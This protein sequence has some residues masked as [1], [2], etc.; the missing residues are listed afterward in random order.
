[1]KT[2]MKFLDY[3]LLTILASFSATAAADTE[4]VDCSNET[5]CRV[6]DKVLFTVKPKS[7]N[8]NSPSTGNVINLTGNGMIWA[9][10]ESNFNQAELSISAP[11]SV[12]LQNGKIIKPVEFYVRSNYSAFVDNYVVSIYRGTD[13]DL[14]EPLVQLP[15]DVKA[16]SSILWDGDLPAK[17]QYRVGDS[18]IYVVRA[19]DK[20]GHFDE[21]YSQAIKLVTPEENERGN[22]AIRDSLSQNKG[23]IM[24]K[25]EAMTES[26]IDSV[27]SSNNLYRQNIPFRGSR[28]KI[29]GT[30]IPDGSNVYINGESYPID[31]NRK[32]AVD[33]LLPIGE[34]DFDITVDDKKM[35]NIERVLTVDVSGNSFFMVG[36]ADVTV[37]QNSAS[38]SNK[39]AALTD[40]EGNYNDK[41]LMSDGRIAF[42][43]KSKIDGRYTITAH[44]DTREKELQH[45]F[46]GFGRAYPEDVFRSLDPDL[47]Y[48]TYGDDSSVYRD[49]D[50]MGRF[51]LRVDWDKSQALWGNFNT[52]IAGTEYGRYSRSL[53]G[54]ALDW[55][56]IAT[57]KFGDT[58]TEL[59]G[60]ASQAQSNPGHSEFL[61][62]GGSLYYLKHTRILSGSDKVQVQISD[63]IT[64][65]VEST[66]SL[67]RGVDYEIDA[68]QGRIILAKPLTQIVRQSMPSI[69]HQDPLNGYEQRLLVDYEYIPTGF[70]PESITSGV[71]GKHWITDNIA[72]GGTYVDENQAGKDYLMKGA[73]VTLKAGNGTYIKAEYTKT[74]STGVP[75]FYSDNGG[76]SFNEVNKV[77]SNREGEA[78]AIE[79]RVN[80]KELGV[81]DNNISAGAWWHKVDK[82]Y[83]T[84]NS[85]NA[86][87]TELYGAEISADIT[88]NLLVYTRHTKVDKGNKSYIESQ[89]SSEWRITDDSTVTA[90]VKRVE[91]KIGADKA[92]GMLAAMQ[93]S[94]QYN[95][96]IELYGSG[97]ITLDNDSGEYANNDAVT[98]GFKYLYGDL[99]SIGIEGTTGARGSSGLLF[100]EH[101]L[102]TDHT[103]YANYTL[104]DSKSDYSS[105]FNSNQGGWTVGQRWR[106]TDR[107][108][109]FNETQ[110]LKGSANEK[111]T[112]NT[113]GVDYLLDEGWSTNV[114]VQD[115]KLKRSTDNAKIHRTAVS[116]S[117]SRTTDDMDWSSKVEYRHDSGAEHRRQWLTTNRVNWKFNESLRLSGKFNYSET[118]DMVT[119]VDEAKFI[120]SGIGFAWRPWDNNQWALFGRY[121]YLYDDSSNGQDSDGYDQKSHIFS[122]EGVHKLNA[123]WEF[124]AKVAYRQSE[125]RFGYLDDWFD[126]S[127]S[128]AAA[129]IRYDLI[130]KWHLMGEYRWLKV[131]DGGTK[132]GFLAG[133]DYDISDYLRFG[134]GYNFTDF[135]DDL[136]KQDYKYKGFFINVVGY[137]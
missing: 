97:Q 123:Q 63:K 67:T 110:Q 52:G 4:V 135:S 80:L 42:Y 12:P 71:R 127:A 86:E 13:T 36:M 44:A 39:E 41:D 43:M 132:Q 66:I 79:G 38:G 93:Y 119:E 11:S 88:D 25:E 45:L 133:I 90:E 116:A 16:I 7:G 31:L 1:M 73:D 64:G 91:T 75:I 60:F 72:V 95:S 24:T 33:F 65:R 83:S 109:L 74:E 125:K 76:L 56:S 115:G 9:S 10:E 107:I 134:L 32:F 21:T 34:H 111:G 112:A 113:I 50:T 124:A 40:S 81:T 108:N 121:N 84:S 101:R 18:L 85:D 47:Y 51:Y 114:T 87:D 26:L 128:F 78:K 22:T 100:A 105:A 29:Q 96:S 106:L 55:R 54:A 99:S 14:I 68:V 120:E 37:Y 28:V 49:V 82:G 94:Y 35:G 137:Y 122:L 117:I 46:S 17:Y 48:P 129:Q 30:N 2:R 61:G 19:Y 59:R 62:T 6:D 136:T 70:E 102:S 8:A 126:S 20:E 92:T 15:A 3:T 77:D 98:A 27:V 89:L 69:I 58:R 103:I 131:K 130:N 53:Y 23:Q 5:E 104:S 118:H 57:T